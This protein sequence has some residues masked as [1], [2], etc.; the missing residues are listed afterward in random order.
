M[1]TGSRTYRTQARDDSSGIQ[2]ERLVE[3]VVEL[4][5]SD[6]PAAL[7]TAGMVD[8]EDSSEPGFMLVMVTAEPYEGIIEREPN[9]RSQKGDCSPLSGD[10]AD[11]SDE[12][13]KAGTQSPA[14]TA[15]EDS[16]D[17]CT[18]H[19]RWSELTLPPNLCP[20]NRPNRWHTYQNQ[21]TYKATRRLG[22]V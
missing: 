20:L 2:Y 13:R 22:S 4:E 16:E 15:S 1:L 21:S 6:V 12:D 14:G 17:R 19:E 18:P 9:D 3:T 5:S 11:P 10:D 8:L 7:V